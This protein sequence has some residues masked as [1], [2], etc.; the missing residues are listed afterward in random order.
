MLALYLFSFWALP[1]GW[2]EDNLLDGSWRYALGKFR[3]LGFSLGRDSWFTYGPLAH[4]FGAPMG[5]ERFQPWP[6]YLLG[7]FIAGVIA[8][9]LTR[10]FEA[11]AL[12]FR[13]RL[14]FALLLP[15]FFLSLE[16]SQEVH[17][18]LA[19]FLV[20]LSCSLWQ[21]PATLSIWSLVLLAACGLLYKISFGM[22]AL[23][24]LIVVLA[25]LLLRRKIGAGSILL[26]LAGYLAL[27]YGLFL[28][29]SGSYDLLSYV[30]LGLETASKYSEIMIANLP[31]SPLNY[32]IALFYL[33]GGGVLTWAASKKMAGRGAALCLIMALLG[34]ALLLF[35][36][37][38]VRADLSHARLFYASVTPVFAL[39]SLV[40]W[41]GFRSKAN[42]E[43]ALLG[44]ISLLLLLVYAV[45]LKFLPGD[46]NPANLPKNWLTLGHRLIAAAQGQEAAE[47]GAKVAFIRKSHPQ[48]FARLNLVGRELEGKG[49]KPRIT[50]YPWEV[51]LFEGVDGYELAASPSLQ[52]YAS[53]PGS[54]V[55][56]L[57]TEFLASARRP[58]VV[59]LGPG[60]IDERSPISELTDLLP[61]LWSFYHLVDVVEGF[62]ILQANEAGR[63]SAR[64][65]SS[66]ETAQGGA[67][68][69]LRVSLDQR[70]D[71][72]TPL[73]RLVATLFKAPEQTVVVTITSAN[74]ERLQYAFRGYLSQLKDGVF[75]AP[76][77]LPEFLAA[78]YGSAQAGQAPPASSAAIKS[79][80]AE[81]RRSDGFWNL[82]VTPR[83]VPLKVSYVSLGERR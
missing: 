13:A 66:A 7:L 33:A 83:L 12:S 35:K 82:P 51:M 42:W 36:H 14:L 59:V 37:G 41:A 73:L 56:R 77:G 5:Q 64:V 48:L 40:A 3:E 38:F 74:N 79:A 2:N 8:I 67:G 26:F 9:H 47:Y 15:F 31:Y 24:A 62:A 16:G 20:L 22:M 58:D 72:V 30:T 49:R 75:F 21:G 76:Q 55:H 60:A 63:A 32:L 61:P 1:Q 53:G 10:V 29:S 25:S 54:R 65:P 81:L 28:V 71:A 78:S 17:L 6:Y 69:W 18:F 11:L 34:A 50:F 80:V 52:I 27:L 39:L 70:Q 45:M 19:L 44:S 43:K 68:E 23:F 4:W 57:E 46:A